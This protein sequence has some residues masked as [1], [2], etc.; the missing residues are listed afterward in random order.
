M[1]TPYLV[2][3]W[4]TQQK[5]PPVMGTTHPG[6]CSPAPKP[7]QRA[8][9]RP[10]SPTLTAAGDPA[11][12]AYEKWRGERNARFG[13]RGPKMLEFTYN[14][15]DSKLLKTMVLIKQIGDFK[16]H[17]WVLHLTVSIGLISLIVKFG[18]IIGM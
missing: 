9:L 5:H 7:C 13:L 3:G 18:K 1:F 11:L 6:G 15:W 2:H 8:V 16:S 12:A 14:I 10:G 17:M 4:F